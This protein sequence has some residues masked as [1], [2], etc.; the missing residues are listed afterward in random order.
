MKR[1]VMASGYF[2]PLHIGHVRYLEHAKSLGDYLIVCVES[3]SKAIAKKGYA[4]M[5]EQERAE[6]VR[7]LFCVDEVII[8]TQST[9]EAIRC[10]QPNIFAK[11]GDRVEGSLPQEEVD[12]CSEI[13]AIIVYGVGGFDKPQSSSALVDK[14]RR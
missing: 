8:N 10:V 3:D 7:A 5:P 11:G 9:A 12:A 14:M 2:D 13:G 1:R 6:I 4:F